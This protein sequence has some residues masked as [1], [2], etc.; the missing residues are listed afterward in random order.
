MTLASKPSASGP[1]VILV[2]QTDKAHIFYNDPDD[3]AGNAAVVEAIVPIFTKNGVIS[4]SKANYL[5]GEFVTV[6]ITDLD[7][8]R[9]AG[10]RDFVR[11]VVTTDSWPVGTNITLQE[12]AAG[13]G[14]FVGTVQIV[15]T[16][17]GPGQVLGAIG[18]TITVRYVDLLG[19]NG[20]R[21]TVLFSGAKVGTSL[22][23][24]QQVPAS[25]LA[26]VDSQGKALVAVKA[27]DL[28]N[29]QSTVM[30]NDTIAHL[31]TYFVQVKDS[32]GVVIQLAWIRD[33][34]LNAGA[35]ATPS[36][37]WIPGKSGTYNV[38]V[39]V[40]D[41]LTTQIALSP[42]QTITVTVG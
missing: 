17:P 16:F 18:D 34:T 24:T 33:I 35:S 31:F 30:N 22:P 23:K 11:P 8:H 14:V 4:T 26:L 27:G 32:S 10:Q 6:T 2:N 21:T 19:D 42:K 25:G 15:N 39:F 13:S 9:N 5:I 12:T 40:W 36:L 38:E 20:G 3:A 1:G 41:G 7:A 37:S 28:V 29:V